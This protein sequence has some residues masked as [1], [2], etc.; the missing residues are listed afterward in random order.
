MA[1]YHQMGHDSY[2]LL[3][4]SEL[5]GYA[6]AI[7]SPVNSAPSHMKAQIQTIADASER[8][9]MILDPQLYFPRSERG[10][11]PNWSYFP[12]QVDSADTASLEWWVDVSRD[13]VTAAE[14]IGVDAACSPAFAPR[15][16]SADYFDLTVKVGSKFAEQSPKL[17][18]LRS[19]FRSGSGFEG[20][21]SVVAR[22]RR[23]AV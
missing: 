16:C 22:R 10:E 14:D 5:D 6:G 2:N 21:N 12:S 19:E 11:L 9:E 8:L 4:E 7:L 18:Q 1:V 15:S 23:R 20:G 17:R 13:L 3:A